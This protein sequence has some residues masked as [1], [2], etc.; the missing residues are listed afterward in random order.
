MKYAILTTADLNTYGDTIAAL[1]NAANSRSDATTGSITGTT[2]PN[3][4][5]TSVQSFDL[6]SSVIVGQFDKKLIG[7]CRVIRAFNNT[8]GANS[9][10]GYVTH[11]A[12]DPNAT[13][14]NLSKS[15]MTETKAQLKSIGYKAL[16]VTIPNND[17]SVL[18]AYKQL[19]F[20]EFALDLVCSL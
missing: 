4:N 3:Y 16:L 9:K 19:K 11:I 1:L 20:N 10:V 8:L 6:S 12:I 13:G 5:R 15:L 14:K 17:A 18:A 7:I 2:T